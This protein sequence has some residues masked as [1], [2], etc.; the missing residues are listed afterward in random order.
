M[1][2][3]ASVHFF[4]LAIA[5]RYPHGA[6]NCVCCCCSATA[7]SV[8]S[9]QWSASSGVTVSDNFGCMPKQV[10][11]ADAQTEFTDQTQQ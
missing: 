6:L 8:T 9:K 1:L 10:S 7:A 11:P 3:S 4:V 5:S 2:L